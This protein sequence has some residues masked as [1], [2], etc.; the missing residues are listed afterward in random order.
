M[1]DKSHSGSGRQQ[2]IMEA[3]VVKTSKNHWLGLFRLPLMKTQTESQEF[4]LVHSPRTKARDTSQ[5]KSKPLIS[6]HTY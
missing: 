2:N 1:K 3:D 6:L 4:N 5:L